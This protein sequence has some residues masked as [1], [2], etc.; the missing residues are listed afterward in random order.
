M[1]RGV[2]VL[3]LLYR[4]YGVCYHWT[5]GFLAGNE[6]RQAQTALISYY[7]DQQVNFSL[8]YETPLL[9]KPWV[10]NL[11]EVPIYEWAVVLLSRAT[12]LAAFHRGPGD[13]RGQCF[14]A[15]LPALYLLLGRLAVPKPRRLLMLAV[16]LAA[17]VYIYYARAFLM[18]ALA[19]A[20]SRLVPGSALCGRWTKRSFGLGSR[21]RLSPGTGWRHW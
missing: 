20:C 18:D 14:Y 8:L 3:A 13:F 19:T 12:E 4:F 10:S 21:S 11:M 6:F 1:L 16:V 9:G 2:F 17:P 5:V 15:M 7:I